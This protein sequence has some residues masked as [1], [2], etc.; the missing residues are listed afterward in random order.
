MLAIHDS[1][2]FPVMY[3]EV[4][5]LAKDTFLG[6]LQSSKRSLCK[7]SESELVTSVNATNVALYVEEIVTIPDSLVV[8][9]P[10]GTVLKFSTDLKEKY[11][12]WECSADGDVC[13]GFFVAASEVC[14]LVNSRLR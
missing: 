10:L 12:E 13:N 2:L 4:D 5:Q 11:E 8:T 1:I 14:S 6:F 9:L 3:S 7:N